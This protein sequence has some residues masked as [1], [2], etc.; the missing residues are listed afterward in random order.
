[1]AFHASPPLPFARLCPFTVAYHTFQKQE[2]PTQGR[3]MHRACEAH[4][5]GELSIF[6]IYADVG[7][8]EKVEFGP[9]VAGIH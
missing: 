7:R 1:M 2:L 5:D 4:V 3:M 6:L 9:T 8:E